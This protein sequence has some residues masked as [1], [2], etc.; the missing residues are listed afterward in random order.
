MPTN[1]T[2]INLIRG[3][4]GGYNLEVDNY[5]NSPTMI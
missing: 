5:Y 1:L 2:M 4:S 3:Y